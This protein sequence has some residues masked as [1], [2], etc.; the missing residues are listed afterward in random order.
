[1]KDW[2]SYL[3][4]KAS[5]D[6][7][8]AIALDCYSKCEGRPPG[9]SPSSFLDWLVD[10][11]FSREL[12]FTAFHRVFLNVA[13]RMLG[14]NYDRLS[15]KT[16]R[17]VEKLEREM[18][19]EEEEGLISDYRTF[20]MAQAISTRLEKANEVGSGI[21]T[22][23]RRTV[24]ICHISDLHFG[25]QHDPRRFSGIDQTF[26]RVD[27]FTAFLR[28]SVQAGAEIDLVVISGDV[29]SVSAEDEY[30]EFVH[31]LEEIER[32]GAIRSGRF[33]ERIVLVPGNHEVSRRPSGGRGDY[34]GQFRTFVERLHG[35]GRLVCSPYSRPAEGACVLASASKEEIPFALHSFPEVGLEVL[36]LVS[37]FYS[38][39]LDPEV[40]ALI[41]AYERLKAQTASGVALPADARDSIER[42]FKR[43]MY[44]DIGFFSPDYASAVPF[45]LS[46][47][48]NCASGP[49]LKLVVAHHPAT[50]YFEMDE[51]T[52]SAHGKQ[53]LQGLARLGFAEYLHGHIHC[54]PEPSNQAVRE[55]ASGTLGGAPSEGLHGFNIL[56]WEQTP[57]RPILERY[58][59]RQNRYERRPS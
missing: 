17:L 12:G 18:T 30:E 58:E 46:K 38:Q 6:I 53:L 9:D 57:G 41:D 14:S 7:W 43:R 5:E 32:V 37:C 35:Q 42:Y 13:V 10:A 8:G 36:T 16:F 24:R 47:A 39:G 51:I 34:L 1:M 54:A 48:R 31:F 28:E 23:R 21:Q 44:L 2:G 40:V 45:E 15:E 26:S 11:T 49:V 52:E 29:T 25:G 3:R 19:S 33:W 50:K 27:Y 59:L 55:I 4:A 56:L 20:G 22:R